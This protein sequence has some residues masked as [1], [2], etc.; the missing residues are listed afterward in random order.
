MHRKPVGQAAEDSSGAPRCP[1]APPKAQAPG[2]LQLCCVSLVAADFQG[3]QDVVS[4]ATSAGTVHFFDAAWEDTRAGECDCPSLRPGP[5]VCDGPEAAAVTDEERLLATVEAPGREHTRFTCLAACVQS[6]MVLHPED[7]ER[8]AAR[9]AGL[10]ATFPRLSHFPLPSLCLSLPVS[11]STA[12]PNLYAANHRRRQGAMGKPSGR[13]AG[14]GRRGGDFLQE[15]QV[16]V[17]EEEHGLGRFQETRR[18]VGEKQD[19]EP[20]RTAQV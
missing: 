15:A 20:R 18:R 19:Q 14:A 9:A 2:P 3:C 5:C 4:I 11:R 17:C 7:G 12:R 8:E 1:A 6:A 13:A 16:G 10:S